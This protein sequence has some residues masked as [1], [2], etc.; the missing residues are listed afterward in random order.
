MKK[1]KVYLFLALILAA[2][3]GLGAQAPDWLWVKG[4]GSADYDTGNDIAVDT[5]GNSY[6]TG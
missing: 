2:L 4:A 6:V 5:A 3:A 1:I